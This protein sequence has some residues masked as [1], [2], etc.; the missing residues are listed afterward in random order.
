MT[1]YEPSFMD[2]AFPI[3]M[4]ILMVA[5]LISIPFMVMDTHKRETQLWEEKGCQMYDDYTID[6]VPAKCQTYFIDHYQS[7]PTR[8]QPPVE[9]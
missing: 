1:L 9:K 4:G 8:T 5:F 7:Q 2:R 6:S 3:A